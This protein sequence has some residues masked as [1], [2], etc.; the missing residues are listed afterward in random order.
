MKKIFNSILLLLILL[1]IPDSAFAA[2]PTTFR[3]FAEI[4]VVLIKGIVSILLVSFGI[5]LSYGV[6]LYF[7][8]SDNEK[9]REEIKGYL[10]WGVIGI[11]VAFGLWGLLAILSATLGWGGVGIPIIRPP[12]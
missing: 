2:A 10:L 9:K 7:I 6:L 1:S 11:I 5:G 3:S 12:S 4:F 8:H